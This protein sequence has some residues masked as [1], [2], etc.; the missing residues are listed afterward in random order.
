[1][2]DNV[3]WIW[4]KN[5]CLLFYLCW[6]PVYNNNKAPR[7][8]VVYGQYTTPPRTLL[9]TFQPWDIWTM[10]SRPV[11]TVYKGRLVNTQ[12]MQKSVYLN[13]SLWENNPYFLHK[14]LKI[15]FL[16]TFCWQFVTMFFF[17]YCV[18]CRI[19]YLTIIWQLSED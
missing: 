17:Y 19:I 8:F 12:F 7:V 13:K 6:K 18:L 5:T 11:T 4:R 14:C 1:V 15:Y 9:L 10:E 2:S 3:P 16:Q